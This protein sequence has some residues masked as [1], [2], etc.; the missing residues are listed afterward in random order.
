[1][2]TQ[3][4][5]RDGVFGSTGSLGVLGFAPPPVQARRDGVLGFAPP[6]A[7]AF[8][9]GSL[10]EYF[11]QSGLGFAP[12]PAQAFRDGSLGEY[13]AQSGLGAD[14]A[15]VPMPVMK[16]AIPTMTIAV[17]GLGAL[18]VIWWATTRRHA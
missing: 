6:P 15:P 7:Q 12:P 14:A 16:A 13:F 4:E 2:F 17:A 1:M 8:R 18:A 9:D 10:G 3:R 11:A 5:V